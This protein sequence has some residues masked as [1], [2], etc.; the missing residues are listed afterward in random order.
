[1]PLDPTK[2]PSVMGIEAA[3]SFSNVASSA[4]YTSCTSSS[5]TPLNTLALICPPLFRRIHEGTTHPTFHI[6]GWSYVKPR[7]EGKL[8][9]SSSTDLR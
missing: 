2:A 9:R 5:T 1:M 6:S 7:V 4:E 8:R 3:R